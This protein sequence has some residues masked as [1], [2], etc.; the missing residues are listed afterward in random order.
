MKITK[1]INKLNTSALL[2]SLFFCSIQNAA[3]EC[4]AGSVTVK[5]PLYTVTMDAN[6]LVTFQKQIGTIVKKAALRSDCVSYTTYTI[7]GT[8]GLTHLEGT[9][10]LLSGKNDF[11]SPTPAAIYLPVINGSIDRTVTASGAQTG[12][13]SDPISIYQGSTLVMKVKQPWK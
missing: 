11:T 9:Q 8:N 12:I 6:R 10:L 4:A 3:A 1:I 2:L 5:G 7:S 13:N